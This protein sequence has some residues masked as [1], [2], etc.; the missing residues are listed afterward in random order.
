MK[1]K[2]TKILEAM[3]LRGLTQNQLCKLSGLSSEARLS[4]ILNYTQEPT[5]DEKLA[6][7]KA[8]AVNFI[9]LWE[10]KC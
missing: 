9:E 8:L 7:A 5:K 3:W 2:R 4:R 1:R 10:E 6:L